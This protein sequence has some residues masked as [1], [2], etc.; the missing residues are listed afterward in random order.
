MKDLFEA[1]IEK[2]KESKP[3][4]LVSIIHHHGSSPRG[5]GSQMLVD[6]D[7]LVVGTIGGG[8]AEYEAIKLA[9]TQIVETTP[10]FIKR[11]ILKKNDIEDLGMVCGGDIEVLFHLINPKNH[12]QT[13]L[14]SQ[15]FETIGSSQN[16][17]LVYEVKNN[18]LVEILYTSEEP[19]KRIDSQ[20]MKP[21]AH[22]WKE[23][24][25]QYVSLPVNQKGKVYIF[26]GGHVSQALAPILI[27]LDFQVVIYEDREE[28]LTSTLFP[29][30]IN[31]IF[32]SFDAISENIMITEEDYAV[33]MTR[34][35]QADFSLEC[36][37][38]ETP[39]DY[40]GV[41]GS[42]HKVALH[43]KQLRELGY[44]ESTISRFHMPIG[45]A[46][47]AETPA[48][49]AIS[50]AAQLIESRAARGKINETTRK[51]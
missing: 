27:G 47:Q 40:L 23:N 2:I 48:E 41:I 17:W 29:N 26:G 49:I 16:S 38:I 35:H 24:Q 1:I 50:I 46:I 18:Q 34:G 13:E 36:Q 28:F 19:I 8:R 4:V 44:S 25:T 30:P 21:A 12:L 43:K 11:F 32:G 6:E 37:L 42:K 51:K 14:F 3:C 7:G 9:Q 39:A 10:Y 31:R 22:Y 33:V 20:H 15:L 45:L 5:T